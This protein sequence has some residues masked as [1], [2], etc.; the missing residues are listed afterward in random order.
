MLRE[1]ALGEYIIESG[2]DWSAPDLADIEIEVDYSKTDVVFKVEDW[3]KTVSFD[4][5]I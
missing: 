4:V 3:E 1:F 2:Y 5:I